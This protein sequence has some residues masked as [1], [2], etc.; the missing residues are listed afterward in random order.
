MATFSIGVVDKS[1]GTVFYKVHEKQ[2]CEVKH[3]CQSLT[4]YNEI[5]LLKAQEKNIPESF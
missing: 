3:R 2:H 5:E 1:M 4:V